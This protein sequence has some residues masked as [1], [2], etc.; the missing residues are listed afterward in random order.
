M[1]FKSYSVNDGLPQAQV[2]DVAQ[3][4][5]GYIWMSTYGGG[6]VKFDGSNFFNYTTEDG[7]KSNTVEHVLVDSKDKIWVTTADGG[8]TTFEGDSLVDPIKND[9]LNNY[10]FTGLAELS[11][12]RKWF[13]TY[14]GG[15]FIYNGQSLSRLTK[16]DGLLNNTVWGFFED[17]Q[18]KIWMGTNQG[19]S[20]YDENSFKNYTKKDGLSGQKIYQI[21]EMRNGE[22]WM[23]TN[24]GI[25]VWDGKEFTTIKEVN[26]KEL[27]AVFNLL[28]AS[29]GDIW[30][31]TQ[32][33]GIFV[34]KDDGAVH[35]TTNNG[36][37]SN[38]A[39]ELFED[40]NNNIWISTDEN[41]VNIYQDRGFTFYDRMTGLSSTRIFSVYKDQDDIL[42][43]GTG[44]GLE[45]FDGQT[46]TEHSLPKDYE[47]KYIWDITGL[48]NGDKLLAMPDYTLMRFD[49]ETYSSFSEAYGLEELYVYDLYLDSENGLWISSG[50]GLYHI[51]LETKKVERYSEEDGLP[52]EEVYYVFEETDGTKWIGTSY[53]LSVF[54][55]ENFENFRVRDGLADNQINYITKSSSGNIWLAT[56]GGVS[57]FKPAKNNKPLAIQNFDKSDGMK[58]VNTHFIWFDEEGYLWQGTNGGLQMLDVPTFRQTGNLSVT[59]YPL[60]NTGIGREFNFQS[61]STDLPNE[62]W[63][64]SM[65]GLVNLNPNKNTRK[66]NKPILNITSISVNGVPVNWSNY[67]DSLNYHNGKVEF[68]NITFPSG[69]NTYEFSFKGKSYLNPTNVSYRYKLKGFDKEWRPTTTNNSAV[70]TNLSPGNYS[71][72]VQANNSG[73]NFKEAITTYDFSIAYPFWHTY[74]F[75]TLLLLATAGMIYGY[76]RI[77]IGYL[78]KN[79]LQELVDEQTHE[80]KVA[81]EEKEVLIKEIHHR[82][83][84]NLAVISGLLE[85]QQ[86]NAENDF[87]SRILS[88]S[89]RR[90][91]SISM[92]HEKL[93][94]NE[95]L[96]EID[97]EKY[98]RELV[99]IISYSFSYPDKDITV[100]V[101]IDD[102]KLG[103]DQGIPCGLILNELVSNAYE[104]AFKE[105]SDGTVAIEIIEK[106]DGVIAIS[107]AD[108]GVG[109]AE[110]TEPQ[111]SDTLGFTLIQ[112][113][114]QQLEAELEVQENNPGSRFLISFQKENPSPK[115]PT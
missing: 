32:N 65:E 2:H 85:L 102:I 92:I 41:G 54:D 55:G 3:T 88:E 71:F 60:S 57:M 44:K 62:V 69:D 66:L 64:G 33:N 73:S 86:G 81:L 103:V 70:Y 46:F 21:I 99:E 17:R 42:W 45:S 7:L 23:A 28:Q 14:K 37:S 48:P 110:N 94:Q 95:R 38:Y 68:P 74:W 27:G 67:I 80:L 111:T 72:V 26:G 34:Q 61:L 59:H 76:I 100:T 36:L 91:Q 22:K 112:T 101:D 90:V 9:T 8:V 115:V 30:I 78:E 10:D 5:D 56:G 108:N 11:D 105:Q 114:C 18:G 113:L 31:A 79:R 84:N 104:H 29:D 109:M 98:V 49:G 35:Y 15:V 89:Q 77:R 83:K 63:F 24:N 82:V 106:E 39:Y 97:F 20:I 25:S 13:G 16:K 47:P 96:A 1:N 19:I 6:L 51:N 93:Y 52:S 75:Y 107:V 40:A 43:M 87:A 12:G 53:G 4:S 50:N 58:L